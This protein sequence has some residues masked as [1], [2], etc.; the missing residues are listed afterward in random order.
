MGRPA[1]QQGARVGRPTHQ[2]R[3]VGESGLEEVVLQLELHVSAEVPRVE[4]GNKRP[5]AA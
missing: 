4:G 5:G 3:H 2:R 1:N